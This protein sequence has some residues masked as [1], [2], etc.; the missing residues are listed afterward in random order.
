MLS[1][2]NVKMLSNDKIDHKFMGVY[3]TT[4]TKKAKTNKIPVYNYKK[5]NEGAIYFNNH[6]YSVDKLAVYYLFQGVFK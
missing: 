6:C 3:S 5:S 4:K 1:N 2:L